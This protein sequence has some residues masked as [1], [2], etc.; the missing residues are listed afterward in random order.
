[1]HQRT[2]SLILALCLCVTCV[3]ALGEEQTRSF[4]L[5]GYE[6]NQYRTWNEN[7]FFEYMYEWTGISVSCRQYGDK[8][9]WTRVKAAYKAGGDMPDVLFKAA[10]TSAEC[11][12]ML[13]SGVLVDLAPYLEAYCPNL[14]ALLSEDEEALAAITLPDGRIAA[15]P[16]LNDMPTQNA[17]WI[18]QNFLSNVR[19]TVPTTLEELRSVL[20]AFRDQDANRNGSLNDEVPLGFLG[21]FDLKFL[22]HAFGL[23]S[24][25][26]NVF[27]RDGQVRFMPLEENYRDFVTWCRGLYADGL[28]DKDGFTTTDTLRQVTDEKK[29][30]VY[31]MILTPSVSSLM[32]AAWVEDYVLVMPFSYEGSQ[33][34]RDFAGRVTTGTFAV[35][36]AC[37]DIETVLSWV[38]RLY[39]AQGSALASVG[40]ENVDYVVDGDGSWRLTDAAQANSYYAVTTTLSSGIAYPGMADNAFQSRFS[41]PLAQKL[42]EEMTALNSVCVRPFPRYSLTRAQSDTVAEMQNRIGYEVDMQLA[43]W[44]LGEDEIS[45]ESFAAF[46]ARLNEYGLQDF[47]AFWQG[48]LEQQK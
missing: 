28:L 39:T 47:L 1:M 42:T 34:Y 9:E 38:D 23:V 41:N 8:A 25:D 35:T 46:E 4:T 33:I 21:A 5:A 44:V 45:D 22:A 13:D 29:D 14:W 40:K 31:G 48:V 37:T 24:N 18:N 20:E 27:V 11:M 12:E 26:Y 30:Q 16:Y 19:K 32:P 36:T 15:L 43:R 17:M 2:L 7:A 6:D 10:L 3:S